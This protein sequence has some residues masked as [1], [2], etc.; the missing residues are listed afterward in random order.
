LS[1]YNEESVSLYMLNGKVVV[2]MSVRLAVSGKTIALVELE[3]E[4]VG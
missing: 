2:V 3:G 4:R 1:E